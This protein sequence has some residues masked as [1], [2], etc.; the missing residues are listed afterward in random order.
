ML[1]SLFYT[2]TVTPY[3]VT[4]L[5]V[6]PNGPYVG[7]FYINR[8]V[9]IFF[10]IDIILTFHMIYKVNA[11]HVT[12]SDSRARRSRGQPTENM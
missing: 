11:P 12:T 4:F 7:L 2:A 1:V 9:D 5:D 3:E 10:V 8:L 6:N